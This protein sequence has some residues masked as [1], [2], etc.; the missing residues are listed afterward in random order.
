MAMAC[1][2]PI[3]SQITQCLR[4]HRVYFYFMTKNQE[5]PQPTHTLLCLKEITFNF[6]RQNKAHSTCKMSHLMMLVTFIKHN[7]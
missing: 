7:F 3:K 1:D 6:K 4:E 2:F 5:F